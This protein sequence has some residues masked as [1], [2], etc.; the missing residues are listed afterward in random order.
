M[1][2][3]IVE[4][5][6]TTVGDVAIFTLDRNLTSMATRSFDEAPADHGTDDFTATL[7][8]RIF[9]SDSDITRIFAASNA[10]QVTRKSG[11]DDAAEAYV[12]AVIADLYRFYV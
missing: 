7:A 1:G 8:G 6:R 3:P 4:L 11:W 10:V 12:A 2:Q 5:D 9:A